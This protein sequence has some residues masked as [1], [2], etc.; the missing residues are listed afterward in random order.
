M[1]SIIDL[2]QAFLQLPLHPSSRHLTT[3]ITHDGLFRHKRVPFGLAS[4]PSVFQKIMTELLSCVEGVQAYLDDVIIGGREKNEH[5]ARLKQVLD[6][7]TATGFSTNPEKSFI[8]QSEVKFMGHLLSKD[9]V[10]PDPKKVTA[11]VNAPS[12]SAP[13]EVKSFLC[14][15]RFYSKYIPNF[16]T[17]TEPL[18][19]LTRKNTEWNWNDEHA[20]A[21]EAIKS[22]IANTTTLSIF[23]NTKETEIQ[24][25]ASQTGL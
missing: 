25:D 17:L 21:F 7:H 5:D 12:P 4:A 2:K 1:F 13:H 15:A 16:S 3:F 14:L 22:T 9:G 20:T 18:L 24:T 19:S 11:I 10:K 23:D 6:I 8:G